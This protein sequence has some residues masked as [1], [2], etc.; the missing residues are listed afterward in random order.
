M[1]EGLIAGLIAGA[2]SLIGIFF[3]TKLSGVNIYAQTVS[4][5]RMDWI[6]VWRE[7]LSKFIACVKMINSFNVRISN[8]TITYSDISTVYIK[9]Y[10]SCNMVL[11]RLNLTEPAHVLLKKQIED[12]LSE[13][14]SKGNNQNMDKLLEE[15]SNTARLILKPEWERVK[16]EAKGKE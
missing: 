4:S 12:I 13:L 14:E 16:K 2:I 11:L 15:L 8:S 6:N 7:N 9:M 1:T 5:N 3:T 10:E